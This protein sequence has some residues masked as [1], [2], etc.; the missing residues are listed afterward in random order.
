MKCAL[1]CNTLVHVTRYGLRLRII[2]LLLS[3][4]LK[5][6]VDSLAS[7]SIESCDDFMIVFLKKY[8]PNG[9]TV[10]LRNEK[11]QFIQLERELTG[12]IQKDLK[13]GYPQFFPNSDFYL[14]LR[15]Q[16]HSVRCKRGSFKRE[17]F[18]GLSDTGASQTLLNGRFNPRFCHFCLAWQALH[19]SSQ[20][21]LPET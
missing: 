13:I 16:K 18:V 5:T 12:K 9:T 4:M 1:L 21:T 3:L 17:I 10:R 15:C 7:N 14:L 2:H 6:W 20:P 19:P 8:F 11:N